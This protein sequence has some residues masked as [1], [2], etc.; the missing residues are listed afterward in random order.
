MSGH[1]NTHSKKLG[2]F[3]VVSYPKIVDNNK[4]K[5][6]KNSKS[7]KKQSSNSSKPKMVRRAVS[8]SRSSQQKKSVRTY[9]FNT[10]EKSRNLYVNKVNS[11]H[12]FVLTSGQ[13]N[14]Y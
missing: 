5:S 12:D 10:P 2:R 4:Q 1:K 9:N 11:T 7:S 6:K 3:Q 14:R 8:K 13:K